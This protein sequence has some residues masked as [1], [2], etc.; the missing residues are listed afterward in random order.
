MK[1]N[2]LTSPNP[3]LSTAG[4]AHEN[5]AAPAEPLSGPIHLEQQQQQQAQQFQDDSFA[6]PDPV[7]IERT[8]YE[9][10]AESGYEEGHSLDHWLE[11][12]RRLRHAPLARVA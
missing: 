9:L 4:P 7:D 10:Y 3:S 2:T 11:A 5:G 1:A 8:A 12:E 6:G